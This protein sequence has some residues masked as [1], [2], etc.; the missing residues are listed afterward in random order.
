MKNKLNKHYD[1]NRFYYYIIGL[2]V[3]II[4]ISVLVQKILMSILNDVSA[5]YS[6]LQYF[7]TYLFNEILGIVLIFIILFLAWE[8]YDRLNSKIKKIN[9]ISVKDTCYWI[10]IIFISTFIILFTINKID[11]KNDLDD[12]IKILQ[13]FININEY[14]NINQEYYQIVNKNYYESLKKHLDNLIKDKIN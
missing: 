12:R 10:V 11:N 3:W 7:N 5:K 14:L 13:P 8:W 4:S 6:H 9:H 2:S 1:E